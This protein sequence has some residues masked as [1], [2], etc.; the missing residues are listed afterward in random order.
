M[1]R[2]MAMVVLM[3]DQAMMDFRVFKNSIAGL[4]G[5]VLALK[6]G[7][8]LFGALDPPHDL[9]HGS[10]VSVW[11]GSQLEFNWADGWLF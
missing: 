11:N 2:A 4:R 6:E 3:R 1:L 5:W 7:V 10:C 8:V 9:I